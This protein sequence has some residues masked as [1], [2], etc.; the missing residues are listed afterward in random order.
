[1]IFILTQQALR[2]KNMFSKN[3]NI[4]LKLLEKFLK[5]SLDESHSA[6]TL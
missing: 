1:M 6:H 3:Y 5:I 2:F 4:N